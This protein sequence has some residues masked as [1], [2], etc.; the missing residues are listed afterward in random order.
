MRRVHK[1]QYYYYNNVVLDY[2]FACILTPN[3][4]VDECSADDDGKDV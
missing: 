3:C 1:S 4:S 2:D